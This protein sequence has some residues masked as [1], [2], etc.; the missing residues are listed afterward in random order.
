MHDIALTCGRAPQ[1]LKLYTAPSTSLYLN[2]FRSFF[3]LSQFLSLFLYCVL[4]LLLMLPSLIHMKSA[5]EEDAFGT[6]KSSKLHACST[7]L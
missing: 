3:C 2:M 7:E 1:I 6:N 4:V 5:D